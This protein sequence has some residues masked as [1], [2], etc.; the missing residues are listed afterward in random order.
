MD[1]G[2]SKSSKK[3]TKKKEKMKHVHFAKPIVQ[4]PLKSSINQVFPFA[5]GSFSSHVDPTNLPRCSVFG[6]LVVLR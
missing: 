3:E 4:S 6:S 5:F 2:L 1:H